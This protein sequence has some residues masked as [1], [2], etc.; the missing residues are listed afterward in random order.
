MSSEAYS[1]Y[2]TAGP[3]APLAHL[4]DA[5]WVYR[6]YAP[7][8][9]RERVLPSGTVELIISPGRRLAIA[10]PGPGA[11]FSDAMVSGVQSGYFDIGTA[12]Q[13]DLV[14][15]HVRPGGARALLGVPADALAERHVE[16]AAL[17]GRRAAEL[18]ERVAGAGDPVAALRV[19]ED[20]LLQTCAAQP[21][22]HP[23][24]PAAL[25]RLHA[26]GGDAAI[27]GLAVDA[28]LSHRRFVELFRREVGVSPKRYATIH[29]FQAAIARAE[30]DE[31]RGAEVALDVGYCDQAHFIRDFRRFAGMTPRAFAALRTARRGVAAGERGQICPIPGP[32][33]V[34][35]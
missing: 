4:V 14:G 18:V 31:A 34:A 1:F 35:R 25:A 22:P 15:V 12:Q 5:I 16:L 10:G 8:H 20:L 29:R 28:G 19:V 26:D 33:D 24:V 2:W 32:G 6:G 27:A 3:S 7:A 11:E 30:R 13:R 23:A 21:A 9:A 17:W